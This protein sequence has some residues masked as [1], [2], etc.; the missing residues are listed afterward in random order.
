MVSVAC[1]STKGNAG[2]ISR[3]LNGSQ[4]PVEIGDA[5]KQSHSSLLSVGDVIYEL[6]SILHYFVTYVTY[7]SAHDAMGGRKPEYLNLYKK[8]ADEV[9]AA[10]KGA[11]LFGSWT[12]A[13]G[14]QNQVVNLWRYANGYSDLDRLYFILALCLLS[15]G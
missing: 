2:W 10:T 11:E 8:Y 14:N 1:S 3:I 6:Q 5:Q 7:F 15:V 4:A 12:V 13:F 9:T